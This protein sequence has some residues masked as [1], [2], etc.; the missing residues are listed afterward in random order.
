MI[1]QNLPARSLSPSDQEM[2]DEWLK[3]NKPL[4]SE[5]GEI[6]RG[7]KE[8]IVKTNE[9]VKKQKYKT[10]HKFGGLTYLHDVPYIR[11]RKAL[12]RC[13]CGVEF[14]GIVSKA[15]NGK[16]KSCGCHNKKEKK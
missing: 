3:K 15:K 11:E 5:N 13:K 6:K 8:I 14:V 12:F 4:I 10:G 2:V 9:N 16:L 1:W 7:K